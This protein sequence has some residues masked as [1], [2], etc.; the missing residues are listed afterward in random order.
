MVV[1]VVFQCFY[2]FTFRF[3]QILEST[4]VILP[5]HVDVDEDVN[6]NFRANT[7]W[8]QAPR[9]PPKNTPKHIIYLPSMSVSSLSDAGSLTFVYKSFNQFRVLAFRRLGF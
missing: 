4:S 8:H 1:V 9:L 3:Y 7:F 6:P 5:N 2:D